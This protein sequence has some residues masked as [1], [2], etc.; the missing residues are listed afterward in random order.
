MDLWLWEPPSGRHRGQASGLSVSAVHP[1]A[2]PVNHPSTPTSFSDDRSLPFVPAKRLR[3][4][5]GPCGRSVRSVPAK[6]LRALLCSRRAADGHA[7]RACVSAYRGCHSFY[8]FLCREQGAS[9]PRHPRAGQTSATLTREGTLGGRALPSCAQR[10]KAPL[11]PAVTA[12]FPFLGQTGATEPEI[13]DLA[14]YAFFSKDSVHITLQ[15]TRQ[16]ES[17][18]RMKQHAFYGRRLPSTNRV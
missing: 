14:V 13:E 8:P 5:P 12:L 10:G 9:P 11:A 6:P 17:H 3:N 1:L 2:E 4:L 15:L 16:R 7:A 18:E